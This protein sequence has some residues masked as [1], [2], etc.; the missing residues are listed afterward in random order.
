MLLSPHDGVGMFWHINGAILGSVLAT[1]A[2]D[3]RADG[4]GRVDLRLVPGKRS[5]QVRRRRSRRLQRSLAAVGGRRQRTQTLAYRIGKRLLDVALGA[6]WLLAAA[7]LMC[8][9]ACG[10]ALTLG[11][12][13]F[14]SQQRVGRGGRLFRLYKFRTLDERPLERSEVEWSAPAAHPFAALLR[15]TGL[16]E[17][18]QLINVLRGEMSLV[19]P[20]PERPHFVKQFEKRLPAYATRHGLQAG[21]T[22]W[23]QVNGFRGDTSIARRLE[24]DLFYLRHGSL[25]FDVW[26]LLLTVCGFAGHLW[27]FVR[28]KRLVGQAEMA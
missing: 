10:V 5:A 27:S 3:E 16:D 17:L 8:L 7:P 15:E 2:W 1:R 22:G 6:A 28:R 23:A 26:I 9:I 21:I 24:Y 20:R 11:R 25:R 14:F 13:I 4:R 18:P 19:G 12:P